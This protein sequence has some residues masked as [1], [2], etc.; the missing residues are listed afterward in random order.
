MSTSRTQKYGWTALPR[1]A[2]VLLS[3]LPSKP[4][5]APD[6]NIRTLFDFSGSQDNE[7][8]KKCN[9][10]AKKTLNDPTYNHSMRVY[11]YGSALV[12]HHFPSWNYEDWRDAYYLSCVFHDIGTADVYLPQSQS[13]VDTKSKIS[14]EFKG[15]IVARDFI[16]KHG[17][18]EDLADSICEAVIRHQDVLVSGG[19]ITMVGQVLQL[20]T[21][22]DNTSAH[23]HLLSPS[24]IQHTVDTFPR[25][26]WSSCFVSVLHKECDAKPWCHSTTFERPGYGIPDAEAKKLNVG[27]REKNGADDE[28]GHERSVFV[29]N[30]RGNKG[31]NRFE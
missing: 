11:V 24:L 19:N 25:L 5:Q 20:G 2:A 7:L 14:F 17:G 12:A 26:K 10:F 6:F 16:L 9:E 30:V 1:D 3:A 23:A 15:G 22:I 28:D 31:M 18:E 21:L 4:S 29:S 8:L 27:V 13:E